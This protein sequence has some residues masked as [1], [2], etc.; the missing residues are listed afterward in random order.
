IH[1]K[2]TY[3]YHVEFDEW[4]ERDLHAMV[5]RDRNHPSVVMWSVGNEIRDQHSEEGPGIARE[6]V[7]YCHALDPTRLV[8]SGNDE[9]ASNNPTSPEYLA[10]FADDIIGYNYPDR[11]RTRR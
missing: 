4:H 1:G 6:L 8:T 11:W 7:A 9:I 3:D 2:N 10:E 5:A